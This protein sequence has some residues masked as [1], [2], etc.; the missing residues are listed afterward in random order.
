MTATDLPLRTLGRTG[1]RVTALGYG[2]MSLDDRFGRVVSLAEAGAVLNAVL[3]AG[4]NYIDTSPDYGPSEDMIGAT[5]AHRRDAY[6][7]ATKC[8]C[9]VAVEGAHVY[10]RANIVAAVEQSLRRLCTDHI[11]VLQFHGSPS[12]AVLEE[13][14]AIDVLR[15]LQRQ[16]TVRFIGAS[17]TAPHLA[18]HIA[19]GAFDVLQIPYSALQR[20]HETQITDAHRAGAGTVI[21]GGVARGAPSTEKQWAI[22]RLPEL[23]AEQPRTVW[24]R[25][26]LDDLLD[27]VSRMA[28]MLRFTLSHPDL[29]TTIVGTAN[30]EHLRQ[31]LAAVSQG[32]L[33][34]DVYE[35][36]CRRLDAAVR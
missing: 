21:R 16:G 33:P 10:T 8:G 17:S 32:P 30:P 7:L 28:F 15:D 34:S 1:L 13:H 2:A 12:L 31:N 14:G 35:E 20:E 6:L 23:P 29:D 11:D 36:A 27:G 5:I 26:A 3:D 4:I 22:R 24:E 9:P 19:T 25:A 18:D